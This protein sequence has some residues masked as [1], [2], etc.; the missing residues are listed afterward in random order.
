MKAYRG[1]SEQQGEISD[2]LAYIDQVFD[3]A[4]RALPAVLAF[5]VA[6][7]ADYSSGPELGTQV[8]DELVAV[9]N[10]KKPRVLGLCLH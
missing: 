7:K 9:A 6:V 8:I 2:R 1:P 4:L 10:E 3:D 5:R